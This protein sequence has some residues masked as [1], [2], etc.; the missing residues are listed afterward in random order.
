[1]IDLLSELLFLQSTI[2]LDNIIL[3]SLAANRVLMVYSFSVIT[4]TAS[5]PST[6]ELS[7]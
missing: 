3:N 5:G 6:I 4:P 7:T 1:M 2:G